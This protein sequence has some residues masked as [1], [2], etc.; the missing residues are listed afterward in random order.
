MVHLKQICLWINRPPFFIVLWHWVYG[1]CCSGRRYLLGNTKELSFLIK[2]GYCLSV[3]F[4]LWFRLFGCREIKGSSRIM[5]EQINF[6]FYQSNGL[7]FLMSSH[8]NI[9]FLPLSR[10]EG[11]YLLVWLFLALGCCLFLF[12][13]VCGLCC[14]RSVRAGMLD[15][16]LRLLLLLMKLIIIKKKVS[17]LHPFL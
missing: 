8:W 14:G 15:H 4:M 10:L 5:G 2:A 12:A 1:W 7:L 3:C 17:N 11:S 16:P 13:W 6:S 9:S